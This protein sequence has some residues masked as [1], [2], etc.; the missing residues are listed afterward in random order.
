MTE[1]F[2]E[3][4][5]TIQ[6]LGADYLVRVEVGRQRLLDE[7]FTIYGMT[8][9]DVMDGLYFIVSHLLIHEMKVT[10]FKDNI[11]R[12]PPVARMVGR[13]DASTD[14][15]IYARGQRT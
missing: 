11:R 5:I 2:G 8:Q 10:P 3:S 15:E 12:K 4:H 13:I 14:R 7:G 6:R 1:A 9:L